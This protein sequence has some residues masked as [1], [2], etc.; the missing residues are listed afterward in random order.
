MGTSNYTV[1]YSNSKGYVALYSSPCYSSWLSLPA[2]DLWPDWIR[3]LLYTFVILYL[4][5]GIAIAADIFMLS[6]EMITSKKRI[7]VAFDYEKKESVERE[8]CVWNETVA[9]LTLMA[10]GSS[11]P[12]I[13][14]AVI[15]TLSSL[16]QTNQQSLGTFTI[17]GSASYNLLV[18]SAVCIVSVPTNTIKRI[19]DFGVFVVTSLWSMFA[20]L[21]LLIVLK[22]SSPD[23]VDIWEAVLTLAFFPLLVLTAWGQDKGWWLERLCKR[24]PRNAQRRPMSSQVRHNRAFSSQVGCKVIRSL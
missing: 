14:I 20:Y 3:T 15:E 6:I 5:I 18:I 10:L 7:I 19:A 9:N 22:W 13:L 11:A 8:V 4:F 17:I 16:G 2:E 24:R 1:R 21:W 23:Q 12:E